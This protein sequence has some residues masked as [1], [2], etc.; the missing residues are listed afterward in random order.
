MKVMT[1]SIT[2]DNLLILT[3]SASHIPLHQYYISILE[4]YANDKCMQKKYAIRISWCVCVFAYFPTQGR[5]PVGKIVSRQ[6]GISDFRQPAIAGCSAY[7]KK[8]A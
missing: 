8:L 2:R 6:N 3:T 7:K 4:K 5:R 1:T